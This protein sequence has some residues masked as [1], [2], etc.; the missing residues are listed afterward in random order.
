M[1]TGRFRTVAVALSFVVAV[2]MLALAGCTSGQASSSSQQSSAASSS[3]A[4]PTLANQPVSRDE[5]F[6]GTYIEITIDDFA[7]IQLRTA[8][9]VGCE[10]VQKSDKL[11]RFTLDLGNETRT[12]FSGIAKAYTEPEKLVGR[13]LIL[14][15]NLKPRKMMG[16][17]SQG[18]LLSALDEGTGTLRLL[19]V[20]QADDVAPGSEVG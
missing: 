20:D 16:E 11:L 14:L 8:K 5:S 15:S 12:V 6:G 17:L 10:K 4:A 13:T 2:G 3:E 1:N 19:T 18:M 9:V 7:K